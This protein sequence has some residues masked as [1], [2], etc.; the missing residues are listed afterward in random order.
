MP[1]A[2]PKGDIVCPHCK[3]TH[4]GS[5][6]GTYCDLAC[7]LN[8]GYEANNDNPFEIAR[9]KKAETEA[10]RKARLEDEIK[11]GS[12][13]EQ[14]ALE[15]E[16]LAAILGDPKM[17]QPTTPM[18]SR[19]DF[20]KGKKENQYLTEALKTI[21]SQE[22]PHAEFGGSL[23]NYLEKCPHY[24]GDQTGDKS[25]AERGTAQHTAVETENLMGLNEWE[26]EAVNKCI[27]LKKKWA[28]GG[29]LIQEPRVDFLGQFGYL[30]CICLYNHRSSARIWDYKFGRN[31]VPPAETNL[32]GWCYALGAWNAYPRLDIIEVIFLMPYLNKVT[33]ATFNRGKHY[34]L[35]A[36][37]ILG[38][39][40]AAK[41][42]DSPYTSGDHCKY[43]G[44]KTS[45]PKMGGLAIT[46]AK[47]YGELDLPD[48]FHPSEIRDPKQMAIALKAAEVM[49]KWVDSVKAHSLAMRLAGTD[50]P[51]YELAERKAK[52]KIVDSNSTFNLVKDTLTT[53]EFLKCVSTSMPELEDVFAS[54]APKGQKG[55]WKEKLENMLMDAACLEQ[56]NPSQYLKRIKNQITKD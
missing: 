14:D 24:R 10:R 41:N 4:D 11:N 2:V 5:W 30:D 18:D 54:Y 51:G 37:K 50:I 16:K 17:Q 48:E 13:R 38:L 34:S 33:T 49:E 6:D 31:E 46:V 55:K 56:G 19:L 47:K 43:C 32:Q 21:Q 36:D 45:C 20:G 52:R 25:F 22:R 42:P 26:V 53:E 12:K 3:K 9:R 15:E 8:H 40:T 44:A 7:F 35:F 39:I 29:E 28:E 1:T 23:M 27:G